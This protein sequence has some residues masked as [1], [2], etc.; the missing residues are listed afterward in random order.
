AA[1]TLPLFQEEIAKKP[2]FSWNDPPLDPSWTK[3]DTALVSKIE[4]AEGMLAEWFAFCQTMP[5]DEFLTTAE[6]LRKAGYRPIRFRPYAEGKN[7]RVAA[8]WTRDGQDWRVASD[9]TP[10]EIRK[11]EEL[12]RK[13]KLLP[14]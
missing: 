13:E 12:N 6:G 1:K 5:L 2:P 14:V 4:A 7:V 3:P 11:Q 10:G 9:K 8:V